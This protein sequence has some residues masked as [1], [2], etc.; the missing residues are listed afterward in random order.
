VSGYAAEPVTPSFIAV[1]SRGVLPASFCHLRFHSLNA[2]CQVSVRRAPHAAFADQGK[3]W[4]HSGPTCGSSLSRFS[5]RPGIEALL[6]PLPRHSG[7]QTASRGPTPRS[8]ARGRWKVFPPAQQHP[9]LPS[10]F[11]HAAN[12][13]GQQAIVAPRPGINPIRC[14]PRGR[15]GIAASDNP[16]R[17]PRANRRTL[18]PQRPLAPQTPLSGPRANAGSWS[19][20]GCTGIF[21]VPASIPVSAA[22][23]F[24]FCFQVSRRPGKRP[25]D[26]PPGQSARAVCA[27]RHAGRVALAPNG[28]WSSGVHRLWIIQAG[29]HR[30]RSVAFYLYFIRH[31]L[32][33]SHESYGLDR[34][35]PPREKD[36]D[37]NKARWRGSPRTNA[38]KRFLCAG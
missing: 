37:V 12:G 28:R 33:S 9:T 8:N 24:C 10:L 38:F 7:F 17:T 18:S 4:T 32:L 2:G 1:G 35:H 26:D 27:S 14:E 23:G 11:A 13:A 21:P 29:Q 6:G 22:L 16:H 20:A 36:F 34:R 31:S 15:K 3:A 19:S 30:Q 25:V 5:S